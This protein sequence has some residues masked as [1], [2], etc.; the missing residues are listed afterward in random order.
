MQQD[1][2][3]ECVWGKSRICRSMYVIRELVC[4]RCSSAPLVCLRSYDACDLGIPALRTDTIALAPESRTTFATS[5]TLNKTEVSIVHMFPSRMLHAENQRTKPFERLKKRL[6]QHLSRAL[7][8]SNPCF[9][10]MLAAPIGR[11]Q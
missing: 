10:T 2:E 6:E 4:H 1:V 8:V 3:R 11:T 5:T 9:I 7:P